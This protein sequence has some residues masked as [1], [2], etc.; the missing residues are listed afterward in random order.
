[1]GGEGR[2]EK[3]ETPGK[4]SWVTPFGES[5]LRESV[6]GAAFGSRWKGG[7]KRGGVTI[8]K[9]KK[10]VNFQFVAVGGEEGELQVK[11]CFHPALLRRGD[12]ET[13]KQW[14]EELR[15]NSRRRS[16]PARRGEAGG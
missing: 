13:G 3:K 7:K 4:V 6:R 10:G 14:K 11:S 8:E 2:S 1:M 16:R 12:R 15:G 5:R 9:K